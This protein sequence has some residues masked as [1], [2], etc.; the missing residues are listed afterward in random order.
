MNLVERT[1]WS[2]VHNAYKSRQVKRLNGGNL[3]GWM[4]RSPPPVAT[5]PQLRNYV[6]RF[7][8]GSRLDLTQISVIR[9]TT[10]YQQLPRPIVWSCFASFFVSV[11]ITGVSIALDDPLSAK[12]YLASLINRTRTFLVI[13]IFELVF[14]PALLQWLL[15]LVF[16][17]NP[18]CSLSNISGRSYCVAVGGSAFPC[19]CLPLNYVIVSC[20][21][22]AF[23]LP[24]RFLIVFD[25]AYFLLLLWRYSH[26]Y[27]IRFHIQ[28]IFIHMKV[29][30]SSGE[31][32]N[33][34]EISRY[35]HHWHHISQF[36]RQNELNFEFV[37]PAR[38]D[39]FY[40]YAYV[41]PEQG[42]DLRE[43]EGRSTVRCVTLINPLLQISLC[44]AICWS[45]K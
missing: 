10:L 3:A 43:G 20:L 22:L 18:L 45:L 32:E 12:F 23:C 35:R 7:R 27:V 44:D 30:S 14:I 40:G 39:L 8:D 24:K 5:L 29:K 36:R 31:Y 9:F 11:I 13:L 1:S 41:S 15:T 25:V 19:N 34:W 37:L 17:K 4:A 2:R 21:K 33:S 42:E 16:R 26:F 38:Q 28:D 6:L